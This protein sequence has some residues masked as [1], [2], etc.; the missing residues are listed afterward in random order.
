MQYRSLLFCWQKNKARRVANKERNVSCVDDL[1][2]IDG[3][4]LQV[5]FFSGLNFTTE[6]VT[7]FQA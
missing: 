2:V 4:E 5:T 1:E 3:A 7:F 6:R